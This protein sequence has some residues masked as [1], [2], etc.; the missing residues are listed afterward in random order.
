M[1]AWNS[2]MDRGQRAA[3]LRGLF[4]LALALFLLSNPFLILLR[5]PGDPSVRHPVSNRATIGS[6]ELQ[7]F[8]PVF[9]QDAPDTSSTQAKPERLPVRSE[10]PV[11]TERNDQEFLTAAP[12]FSASLWFRP[13]PV[14]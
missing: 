13:P 9:G 1:T 12:E 6:S 5:A 7:H 14:S 10:R 3:Y 4:C 8:S 2:V 11:R